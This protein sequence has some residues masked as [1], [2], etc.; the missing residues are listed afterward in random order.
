MSIKATAI[1][2]LIPV[3]V[4]VVAIVTM[5]PAPVSADTVS[6]VVTTSM[7]EQAIRELGGATDGV[8]VV[9]LVPPGSCPGHF[10]I[11]PRS[12]PA[13]RSATAIVRH[14]FQGFLEAKLLE[15]GVED[16]TVVVAD[17]GGSLLVPEHY[18]RLVRRVGEIIIGLMPDLET[19]IETAVSA[20][21]D[22]MAGLQREIGAR[23]TPWNGAPVIAS[24]QQVQ[25]SRWLGLEVVAVIGRPEDTSPR[26]FEKLMQLRPRFVVANL[27]EGLEAATTIADR[28]E[29]PLVVFSNFPGADGYGNGYDELVI[30]DLDRLDAAW[31]QR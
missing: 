19:E 6:L 3:A 17:A 29:V 21:E 9:R 14:E 12:V 27:Q 26:D 24:F 22:R 13:L 5:N 31:G 23:P 7:L 25:F 30:S 4:V 18:G 11:S 20:V 28:L 15:M 16:A 1:S 8:E 10:D 2:R